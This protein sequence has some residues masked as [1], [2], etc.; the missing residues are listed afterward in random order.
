[1]PAIVLSGTGTWTVPD[2]VTSAGIVIV[3]GGGGGGGTQVDSWLAGGGGGGGVVSLSSY[4]LTPGASIEYSVGAGGSGA[5]DNTGTS[6]ADGDG[7]VFN[8][9]TALG[10]G[11][12]GGASNNGRDGGSGGGAGSPGTQSAGIALQPGSADGGA[13]FAGGASTSSANS[14]G[15][16][17]GG[18]SSVAGQNAAGIK[19]GNGGLGYYIAGAFY[20]SGGGGGAF[21]QEIAGIGGP[22]AGSGGNGAGPHGQDAPNGYGG[23]GG[24]AGCSAAASGAGGRGGDGAILIFV[25]GLPAQEPADAIHYWPLDEASGA[26]VF[27]EITE[28]SATV[29]G[30]TADTIVT[31]LFRRARDFREGSETNGSHLALWPAP[32]DPEPFY[33]WSLSCWV[34]RDVQTTAFFPALWR[35]GEFAAGEPTFYAYMRQNGSGV[36]LWVQTDTEVEYIQDANFSLTDDA[37]HHL[38]I[39]CDGT[40]TRLLADGTEILSIAGAVPI[41]PKSA[42][43]V[44]G[45]SGATSSAYCVA[46]DLAIFGDELT[47]DQVSAVWNGGDGMS[48]ADLIGYE[49]PFIPPPASAPVY[50]RAELR[51][52]L[53]ELPISSWQATMQ[54]GR[55]SYLQC[56]VP[57]A[58]QYIAAISEI[59]DNAQLVVIRGAR[60]EGGEAAEM[61]MMSVG[62]QQVTYQ[63]GPFRST[64][65]LS[66][67]R[68]ISFFEE[69]PLNPAPENVRDL[70]GVQAVSIQGGFPRVRCQIDWLLRPGM[71]A[72]FDEIEFLVAYI[73]YYANSSQEYMDVGARTL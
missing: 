38:A 12:G 49:E 56:V 15:G 32:A 66:G 59:A 69:D 2:G 33:R 47:A 31:G 20:G 23:G 5:L 27:N 19:A 25:D 60:L 30:H 57:A 6:G 71:I 54:L 68:L 8:G 13:G 9:I 70:L 34:R 50:Y 37:W 58:E 35:F 36:G 40:Q 67:Y 39:L 55:Q 16:G 62:L 7:S 10:G 73:N 44:F 61:D 42:A 53:V 43:S 21:D 51:G 22:N 14:Y 17:G 24:G 46:D 72:V 26:S 48:V 64:V 3:G 4:A 52:S 1:M 65:S 29:V 41:H 18:G 45:A 11:G 28:S 63:R